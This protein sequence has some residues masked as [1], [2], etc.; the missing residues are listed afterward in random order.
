M[1]EYWV[2]IRNESGTAIRVTVMASDNYRAIQLA[3]ALYGP[4]LI[5]ESANLI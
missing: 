2:L 5:S 1:N 4:Q 3:K